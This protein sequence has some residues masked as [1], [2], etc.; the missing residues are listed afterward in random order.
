M[1]LA[2]LVPHNQPT[3][4]HPYVHDL[5]HSNGQHKYVDFTFC[6]PRP[7]I[8]WVLLDFRMIEPSNGSMIAKK[9]WHLHAHDLVHGHCRH[10]LRN[11]TSTF[12]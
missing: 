7:E 9:S 12:Y 1:Q 6:V 4:W 11:V 3:G 8:R 2:Q 5:V 10:T